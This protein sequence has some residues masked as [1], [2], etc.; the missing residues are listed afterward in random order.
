MLAKLQD[1]LSKDIYSE[2]GLLAFI[3]PLSGHVCHSFIVVSH[4]IAGSAHDHAA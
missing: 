3:R 2:H 1:V 4:W